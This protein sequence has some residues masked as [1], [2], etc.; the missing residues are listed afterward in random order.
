MAITE[1]PP[2]RMTGEEPGLEPDSSETY[3]DL[4]APALLLQVQDDLGRSRVREA[5]WISVVVHLAIILFLVNSDRIFGIRPVTVLTAEDLMRQK[6]TTFLALPPDEQ[7]LTQR[8]KT[9]VLSDKDRIATSRNPTLDRKEL[10]KILDAHRPGPRGPEAPPQQPSP[11]QAPA[12]AQQ[13]AQ[14]QQA[15]P[16]AQPNNQ[17]NQTAR[18]EGLPPQRQATSSPNPFA[19]AMA[20]GSSTE[21]AARAAAAARAGGAVG[22][23]QMGMGLHGGGNIKSDME[24]LTDTQGVDFGPYLA[25]VVESVR[26]NWYNL[27]PEAARSPLFKK[28]VVTIDFAIMKDGRVAGMRVDAPSGDTSLDRAAWGGISASNPFPPLPGEFHGQ[29]LGLRFRFYYNPDRRDLR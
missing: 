27:I 4:D 5:F 19:A 3:V 14:Q 8:P 2:S 21:Q 12:P 9:D 16:Q 13:Q 15:P 10:Q 22:G 18:L 6:D 17:G 24:I 28:G 20:P 29:Y 7:K 11:A 1:I 25:R 23:G 26:M